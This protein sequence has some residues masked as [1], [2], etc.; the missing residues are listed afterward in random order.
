MIEA[1][2]LAWP[3]KKTTAPVTNTTPFLSGLIMAMPLINFASNPLCNQEVGGT[4]PS[5]HSQSHCLLFPRDCHRLHRPSG[6]WSRSWLGWGQGPTLKAH[7]YFHSIF[8]EVTCN[9]GKR[10]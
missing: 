6:F 10:Y 3:C 8:V 1:M 9:L 5:M 4:S 7:A 2:P